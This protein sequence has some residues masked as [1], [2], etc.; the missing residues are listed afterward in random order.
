MLTVI[1]KKKVLSGATT[2]KGTEYCYLQM[3]NSRRNVSHFDDSSQF[4][5][6][7]HV[8]MMFCIAHIYTFIYIYLCAQ[9]TRKHVNHT[10]KKKK[11]RKLLICKRN[12]HVHYVAKHLCSCCA[13]I[14]H[15][16]TKEKMYFGKSFALAL[17]LCERIFQSHD[18][19][20]VHLSKY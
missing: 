12:E 19:Q 8:L 16:I 11:K 14:S 4:T 2:M 18:F 1:R 10:C 13:R 9:R 3:R 6:G 20:S 7:K 17:F 5:T 15:D